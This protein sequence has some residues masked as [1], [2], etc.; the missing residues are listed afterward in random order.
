MKKEK[1]TSSAYDK[2]NKQ[3]AKRKADAKKLDK[4]LKK[5]GLQIEPLFGEDWVPKDKPTKK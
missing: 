3:E 5:G 2:I 4:A 1:A